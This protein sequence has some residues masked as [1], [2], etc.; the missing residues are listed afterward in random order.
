L[1]HELLTLCGVVVLCA[2]RC[3]QNIT[4]QS[5]FDG[6][7]PDTVLGDRHRLKQ[8]LFNLLSNACKFTEPGGTIVLGLEVDESDAPM[9]SSGSGGS[10]SSGA[11]DVPSPRSGNSYESRDEQAGFD[12]PLFIATPQ[13]SQSPRGSKGSAA[14]G[15]GN[16]ARLFR[17]LPSLILPERGRS[18]SPA[19]GSPTGSRSGSSSSGSSSGG[20]GSGRLSP[21]VA[22]GSSPSPPSQQPRAVTLRFFVR[23]TGVGIAPA[24]QQK[25]FRPY[26]Q[27]DA[28]KLQKAGGTGLGLS[29]AHRIVSLHGGELGVVSAPGLCSCIRTSVSHHITRSP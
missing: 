14:Q 23:D 21:V 11:G 3:E 28:G 26:T 16:W 24:D 25:L 4:L 18:P 17:P 29:I 20:S 13:Q 15:N 19:S 9:A 7:L 12:D 22:S 27:I 8:V 1:T 10:G 5:S 6:V 2:V